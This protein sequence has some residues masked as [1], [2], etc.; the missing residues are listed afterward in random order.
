MATTTLNANP[1]LQA[2]IDNLK[3]MP[4]GIKNLPTH[5]RQ[6]RPMDNLKSVPMGTKNLPTHEFQIPPAKNTSFESFIE[7]AGLPH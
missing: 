6:I 4:M 1:E 3:S 7:H 5:E 2:T